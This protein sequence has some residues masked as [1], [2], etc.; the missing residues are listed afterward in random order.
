MYHRYRPV[1]LPG[2]CHHGPPQ[3]LHRGSHCQQPPP[4]Q[5]EQ[6]VHTGAGPDC[7]HR[8]DHASV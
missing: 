7:P 3:P 4:E 2:G 8:A 5:S 1:P 6:S